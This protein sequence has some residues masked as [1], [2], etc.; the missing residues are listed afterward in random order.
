MKTFQLL[1]ILI[2]TAGIGFSC[3][4]Q[5]AEKQNKETLVKS[6]DVDV[7]YFHY[8]RRCVTCVSVQEVSKNAV[9]EI[10][11]DKVKFHEYNLDDSEGKAM[12]EK[13][14]APGQ[15]LMIVNGQNKINITNEG[16]LYARSNPEKLKQIVKEKIDPLL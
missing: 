3:N 13:V 14:G 5:R 6:G 7:Y 1:F 4:T 15:A 12:M 2:I 8:S 9:R 10:Y 16:F 11:G